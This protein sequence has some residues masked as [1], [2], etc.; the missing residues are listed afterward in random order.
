MDFFDFDDAYVRRLRDGDRETVDHF[1]GYFN[2]LLLRVA[3]RKLHS[4][5]EAEDAVQE[6][7]LRALKRLND[8]REGNKLGPFM[9]GICNNVISE[10]NRGIKPTGPL[11]DNALVSV[12]PDPYEEFRRKQLQVL[13]R[14][15]LAEFERESPKDAKLL[16]KLFF[17]EIEK[18]E[19][20]RTNHVTRANLR[21]LLHRAIKKFRAL[22]KRLP[23]K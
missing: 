15:M 13:V 17:D 19:L 10:F 20:C 14:D 4:P 18:D 6:T 8:L 22:M 3:Q 16:R 2:E 7:F 21:V 1:Y 9:L 5:N 12:A 11:D 23:R